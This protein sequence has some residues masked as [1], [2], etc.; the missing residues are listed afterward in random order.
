[1]VRAEVGSKIAGGFVLVPVASLMAAWRAC[2]TSPLGTGDFRAWLALREMVARRCAVEQDRAPAYTTAELARLLGVTQRRARASI[3][4]LVAAGLIEWSDSSIGFPDRCLVAPN[5]EDSIG[6]GTGRV[7]IPR[8]MLRYLANGARPAL[9]ATALGVLF[10][11]LSR[12]RNGFDGRGRVKASWVAEVFHVS[13]RQVKAARLELVALG[14]LDPEPSPQWTEQRWGRAF[15]VRLDWSPPARPVGASSSP[16]PLETG[17]SSSP[18]DLQTPIPSGREKDQEPAQ[19]G[20]AGVEIRGTG[21][22]HANS[23]P[24]GMK[25]LSSLPAPTLADI[26]PEDLR[27][28]G[29]TLDLHTQAVARKLVGSSENDRLKFL[30]LAEHARSV[31]KSNPPGLFAALLRRGAWAYIT[32]AEEEAS[33][34]KLKAHLWGSAPARSSV[35]A[36]PTRR[37]EPS[38]DARL[39][40]EIRRAYA[41]K[42][43]RGDP[44]PQVRRHDASWTRERWDAA[45]A[46]LGM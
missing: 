21:D 8:R 23:V 5:L 33:R 1:M 16:L 17:A 38:E 30:A 37:P 35:A 2:Q 11:C 22:A 3:N 10:R 32:Q 43:F 45:M 39:V 29:R 6:G 14:W 36:R 40:R 4:R 19:R 44:F 28:T 41:A 7:A 9:I 24:V 20:P 34:R 27:D 18:P 26:R 31:G 25:P 12:R 46:E 15:H 42:G 13:I